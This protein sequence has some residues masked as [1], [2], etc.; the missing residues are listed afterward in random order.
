MDRIILNTAYGRI[1]SG[2]N[3]QRPQEYIG[4]SYVHK[5]FKDKENCPMLQ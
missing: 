5:M 1:L 3:G 4:W 2:S